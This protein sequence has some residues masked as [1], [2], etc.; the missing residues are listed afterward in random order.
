MFNLHL[1][2]I[3]WVG[4][5]LKVSLRNFYLQLKPSPEKRTAIWSLQK[6]I[7]SNFLLDDL[8]RK[9]GLI[10]NV[11]GKAADGKKFEYKAEEIQF[12]ALAPSDY[13]KFAAFN[14]GMSSVTRA[15]KT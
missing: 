10:V 1:C 6:A 13:A 11:E 15:G 2:S 7:P 3:G 9:K 5:I 8:D 4:L 14:E 12:L